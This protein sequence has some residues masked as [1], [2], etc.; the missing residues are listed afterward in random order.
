MAPWRNW[1]RKPPVNLEEWKLPSLREARVIK[2]SI[3]SGTWG[4]QNTL[5]SSWPQKGKGGAEKELGDNIAEKFP[6]PQI[7][8]AE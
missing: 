8:E 7:Q 1:Q 2:L 3:A 6:D 5:R 4:H